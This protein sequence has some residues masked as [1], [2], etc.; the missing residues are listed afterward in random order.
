MDFITAFIS[1]LQ[2]IFGAKKVAT[3]EP[4]EQVITL[5]GEKTVIDATFDTIPAGSNA[6]VDSMASDY[7]K[8][9][10]FGNKNITSS[11]VIANPGYQSVIYVT[12]TGENTWVSPSLVGQLE[13]QNFQ[14]AYLPNGMHYSAAQCINGALKYAKSGV[15]ALLPEN[16]CAKGALYNKIPASIRPVKE[17]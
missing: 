1:F 6:Y 3:E 2:A 14:V 10:D 16:V 5:K 17:D 4:V 11:G 12:T 7:F 9:F 15:L 8:V 13:T